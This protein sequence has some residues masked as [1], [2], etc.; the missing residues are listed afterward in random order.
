ML[1]C[2]ANVLDSVRRV[3]QVNQGK[4]T[5]GVDQLGN[6]HAE[7]RGALC[8]KL[9]QLECTRCTRSGGSIFRRKRGNGRSV[10]PPSKIGAS[11]PW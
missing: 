8:R 3:T 6:D 7:E 2:T 10:F 9:H 11:K 4:M 5:A 1:R